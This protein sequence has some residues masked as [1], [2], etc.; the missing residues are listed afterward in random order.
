MASL[1]QALGSTIGRKYVMAITGLI[2][3]G[4][5]VSHLTANLLL[6]ASDDGAAFNTYAYSLMSLGPLLWVAE[7]FLAAT[8]LIHVYNAVKITMEKRAARTS[9]YQVTANAGGPSRKTIASMSMIYTGGLLFVFMILHLKGFKF[10][11]EYTTTVDGTEMRDLYRLVVETYQDPIKVGVYLVMMVVLG[12]HLRHAVWS[13]FQSLGVSNQ[14]Y[15]ALAEK[16]GYAF[17][18]LVALGFFLIP[19]AIFLGVGQ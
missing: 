8:F 13:A 5:L 19:L 6:L 11:T 3:A 16:G 1:A 17:A 15:L 18:L 9:R 4:F 2:W 10:G 14:K 12:L 7:G